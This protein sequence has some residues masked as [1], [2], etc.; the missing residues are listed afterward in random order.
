MAGIALVVV[1]VQRDFCP[2]GSLAVKGGDEVV[3]PLNTVIVAF[4]RANLP[5]FFTRDWHPSDHISFTAQGGIWPR[6]CVKGSPGAG[7]HPLLTVPVRAEIISKA[8]EPDFEAYSGFQGTDLQAR[9]KSFG[10]DEIFLGGLTTDY[11]VKEST[12]DARR[13]GFAVNVI[14]DCTRAVNLR[15]GDG[16]AALRRMA[17]VGARLVTSKEVLRILKRR[18]AVES[19]S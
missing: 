15:R 2:G 4:E 19:S 9:L 6:H 16:A 14:K 10:V 18:V 7:F 1:D 13:A 17:A 11:C 12:I 8:T 5:I 3:G